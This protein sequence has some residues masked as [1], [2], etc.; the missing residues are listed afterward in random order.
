MNRLLLLE[1]L[2]LDAAALGF[3]EPVDSSHSDVAG[4]LTQAIRR[5]QPP[6]AVVNYFARQLADHVM[7][8]NL[9][10]PA[11]LLDTVIGQLRQVELLAECGATDVAEVASRYAEFCGWLHQDVGRNG[12][13]L[14]LTS[15]SVDF[16]EMAGNLELA[17]YNRM[18]KANLLAVAGELQL[19]ASVAGRALDDASRHFPHLVPVCLRQHALTSAR[20]KDE[21]GARASIERALALTAESVDGSGLATYCTTGYVQMEAALCLLVLRL[22]A[23]AANVCAEALSTWPSTLV[24]DRTVCHARHAIALLELREFEEACRTAMLALDGVRSAPSGRV[25]QQLRLVV[26]RLHPVGRN[27]YVRE[28]TE[29]LAEVV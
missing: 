6:V 16:A 29:A 3:E 21:H 25:L 12:E 13:A 11:H 22:P 24:R 15:R 20:L 9:A 4:L 8:D 18:R 10:G 5:N 23:E 7:L 19:A 14:R 27:A 2:H 28:L 17:T 1:V 26:N